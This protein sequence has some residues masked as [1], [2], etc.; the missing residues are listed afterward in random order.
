MKRRSFVK[1]TAAG[2][3][4]AAAVY[5]ASSIQGCKSSGS[6]K[7]STKGDASERNYNDTYTGEFLNRLA[8]PLGGIGAGMLCLEGT[9]ALSHFSLRNKPDIFNEPLTFSAICIKGKPNIAR[10]LEGPVPGWKV[11]GNPG[12]G[13]GAAGKS[14]GLPRF[15]RACFCS[16]R[17]PLD[18]AYRF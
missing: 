12:T 4:L 2:A 5:S 6:G 11:F 16:R 1:E 18:L 8:F 17:T 7:K 14:Y 3:A 13:N 15:A 9:G 10:V